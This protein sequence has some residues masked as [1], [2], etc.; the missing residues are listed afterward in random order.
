MR[1]NVATFPCSFHRSSAGM[2]WRVILAKKNPT[3][4]I[5]FP[6]NNEIK[7]LQPAT[8]S[9]R[10]PVVNTLMHIRCVSLYYPYVEKMYEAQDFLYPLV[11]HDTLIHVLNRHE[12]SF[13][14]N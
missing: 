7:L 14:G 12:A 3:G 5:S 8:L 10:K 6:K 4:G 11:C 13:Y 2:H 1:E 9:C